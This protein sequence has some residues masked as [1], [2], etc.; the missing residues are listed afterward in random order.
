MLMLKPARS[1]MPL[2]RVNVQAPRA[3]ETVRLAPR[4]TVSGGVLLMVMFP[5]QAPFG[6]NSW[7]ALPEPAE[8]VKSRGS[9]LL[10]Q[11]APT[12]T[13]PRASIVPAVVKFKLPEVQ[14]RLPRTRR[15]AP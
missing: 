10:P 4:V 11:A 15:T 13:S 2:V 5:P 8:P 7:L 6:V 9:E 3:V 12:E 14:V 1:K